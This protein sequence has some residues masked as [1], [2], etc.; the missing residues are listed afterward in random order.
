MSV[1]TVNV[2]L[3]GDGVRNAATLHDHLERHG[4]ALSF[5]TSCKEV[6][7]LVKNRRF[8]LVLSEFMLSDGTAYGLMP[9]L[10]GTETTMFF[11]NAVEDGCWW[12]NAIFKGHDCSHE[13]GMRPSEFRIRLDELL[14]DKLFRASG[15]SSATGANSHAES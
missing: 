10:R 11:S 2:L 5:A 7:D 12:M 4:C 3:V 8:D 1:Q 15:P 9:L 14:Y 13:P 6:T